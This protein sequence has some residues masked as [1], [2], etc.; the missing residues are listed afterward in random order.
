M[1]A[2]GSEQVSLELVAAVSGAV[3]LRDAQARLLGAC[4]QV[5]RA[6]A[7]A[8]LRPRPAHG[9][10]EILATEGRPVR[11]EYLFSNF[12]PNLRIA[13]AQVARDAQ[14]MLFDGM[15]CAANLE[16]RSPGATGPI[17]IHLE[18]AD[19]EVMALETLKQIRD[20][21]GYVAPLMDHYRRLDSRISIVPGQAP[22][23]ALEE[24]D[25]E[26]DVPHFPELFRRL[27]LLLGARARIEG[28]VFFLREGGDAVVEER[29]AF[30]RV[31]EV[32]ERVRR[33][34]PFEFVLDAMARCAVAEAQGDPVPRE[35]KG[36]LFYPFV[37]KQSALGGVLLHAGGEA[38]RDS[39]MRAISELVD[40]A[41]LFVQKA[42]LYRAT[43][44][45]GPGGGLLLVGIPREVFY[46]A[47][48]Y[49]DADAPV[50]IT[51]ET[52]TGKE[53]V[54][55]YLH[56]VGRRA[57]GPFLALN[58]AELVETLAE[59]QL[60]GHV[61]GAFTGATGDAVGIFE[62]A[63]GGTLFL[64]EIHQLSPPIQGKL[65]RA[66][67]TG[68]V[69]PVGSAGAP[70][71]V[72]VRVVAATNR[73]LEA[74]VAEGRFFNDLYMRL[75]V[76]EIELPPLRENR[77][78]IPKIASALLAEA[79]ERHRKS[80]DGFSPQARQ[81]LLRYDYPGNIRELKNV[82][83]KAV[84]VAKGT[85]VDVDALPRKMAE[86]LA[87]SAAGGEEFLWDYESY[88]NAKEREYLVR[89]MTRVQGNV[90]EAARVAGI[91][92]THVYNLLKKHGLTPDAFKV[93]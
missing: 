83:E 3:N 32:P 15:T 40:T 9:T 73:N 76:L 65:L 62:Q 4:R 49:S 41:T 66:I 38:F 64:D 30:G 91:H 79:A 69:R 25:A 82:I 93:F 26:L 58:C 16:V 71:R 13:S 78:A 86:A 19:S 87:P 6:D 39:E 67:E 5:A 14:D 42:L 44:G 74:Q 28:C 22:D 70:R 10:V 48:S 24:I 81:A 43:R 2:I 46:L 1:A 55:R 34:S 92:R 12:V 61:R 18:W 63:H 37:F 77:R 23:L 72:H 68:E 27:Y 75:N 36:A 33:G 11:G 51:G 21:L 90:A 59:S 8:V 89:L 17:V 45:Q 20:A 84:L 31:G 52:G 53:S 7:G 54:A 47:E 85:V 60:F 88:K 80:V 57:K 35:W 29:A 50:L 56:M